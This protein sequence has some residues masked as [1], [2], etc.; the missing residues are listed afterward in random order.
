M[1][2]LLANVCLDCA[3]CPVGLAELGEHERRS[4][5]DM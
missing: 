2:S 1:F 3:V 4:D 5:V